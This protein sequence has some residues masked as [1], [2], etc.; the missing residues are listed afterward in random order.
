MRWF[1]HRRS[2]RADVLQ[3]MGKRLEKALTSAARVG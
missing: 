1:G 3:I 2:A